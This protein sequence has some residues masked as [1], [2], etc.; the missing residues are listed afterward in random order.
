MRII[1]YIASQYKRD[2][3]WL[4]RSIPSKRNY[5]IMLAVDDSKSMDESGS[6]QLAFETLALVSKSL[7]ML[8]V[9]EICIVGFGN[10][11]HVAHEFDKPFSSDAG[12]QIFQHF[13][14]QQKKTNVRKLVGDSITLFREARRKTFNAG[15]QLWQL[16]IIISDGV[17]EHHDS[18]RRLVRQAQEEQIMIVFVIVDALLK[19]ESIMDMNQAVFEPDASGE[20]QLKIKR[21]LDGFPFTYYLVVGEVRELPGVLAQALRQWFAEVV[22]SG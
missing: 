5:Q 17:C 13:G 8:E 19:E 10:E 9:G 12:C 4:R 7:S 11:V 1:P 3:I 16:E 15:T 2:K 20:T 6:G 14:F 18:I 21:Y 22:E